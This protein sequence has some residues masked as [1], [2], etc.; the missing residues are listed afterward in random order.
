M[1]R[2]MSVFDLV[3]LGVLPKNE[4]IPCDEITEDLCHKAR[5]EGK[6]GER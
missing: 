6:A 2:G 1:L 4:G 3:G 5:S